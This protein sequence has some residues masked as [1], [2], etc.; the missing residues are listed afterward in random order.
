MGNIER[1]EARWFP[2]GRRILVQGHEPGRGSR[3]YVVD[4]EGGPV[5]PVSGEGVRIDGSNAISPDGSLVTATDRDGKAVVFSLA[6]GAPRPIPGLSADDEISRW[7]EDGRSLY[8]F[9]HG[10]L[11]AKVVRLNL[12][13]GKREPWKELLPTDP[14]GVVTI[15]PILLTPD[16]KTYAYSYPR[17]LSQ[18]FLGEGLK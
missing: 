9:R 13:T 14:A 5:R 2:D 4:L 11:P 3:L 10:E 8:V 6:G 18:L 1:E 7:T 16:G 17:I 12:A 15:T